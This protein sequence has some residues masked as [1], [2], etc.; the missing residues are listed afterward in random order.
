MSRERFPWVVL[1][2]GDFDANPLATQY[3]I[4]GLPNVILV[5]KEGKVVSTAAQGAELD[6]LLTKLLGE[7]KPI[8][9]EKPDNE[10]ANDQPQAGK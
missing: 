6:R 5:D 1:S 3:G 7:P 9:T 10:A 4:F 8:E 2:D